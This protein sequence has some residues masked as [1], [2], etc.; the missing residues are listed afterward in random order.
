MALLPMDFSKSLI[1]QLAPLI[2]KVARLNVTE[3]NPI[4]II[5]LLLA[6]M[7]EEDQIKEAEK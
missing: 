2:A 7:E 5:Y 1:V 3:P 6:L 4:V